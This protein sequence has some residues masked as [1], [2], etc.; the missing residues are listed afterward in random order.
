VREEEFYDLS[1]VIKG[2]RTILESLNA[3]CAEEEMSGDNAVFCESESTYQ[4][5]DASTRTQ[6]PYT[7]TFRLFRWW[8]LVYT[9]HSLKQKRANELYF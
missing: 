6:S 2:K 1:L 5:C 4:R 8:T 7:T 9:Y 3:L